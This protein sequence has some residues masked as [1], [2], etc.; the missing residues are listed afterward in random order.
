MLVAAVGLEMGSV[1]FLLPGLAAMPQ[2]MFLFL[3]N[4]I[5]GVVFFFF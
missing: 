5:P 2:N 1:F 4:W 3:L